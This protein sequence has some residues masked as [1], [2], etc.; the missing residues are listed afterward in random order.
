MV[1]RELLLLIFIHKK[2]TDIKKPDFSKYY[3]V[4]KDKKQKGKK[5]KKQKIERKPGRRSHERIYSN[6][7]RKLSLDEDGK[8][9]KNTSRLE[10]STEKKKP[11][12]ERLDN[13]GRLEID[14]KSPKKDRPQRVPGKRRHSSI[15]SS[16]KKR[17][18]SYDSEGRPLTNTGRLNVDLSKKKEKKEWLD[19]FSKLEVGLDGSV[20]RSGSFDKEP[21]AL[22]KPGKGYDTATKTKKTDRKYDLKT[23]PQTALIDSKYGKTQIKTTTTSQKRQPLSTSTY[24]TGKKPISQKLQ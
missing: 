3:S 7:K 16:K 10:V 20:K 23:K 11:K 12:R 24:G 5:E 1:K 6:T 18:E 14:A 17:K 22:Y 15:H 19:N 21:R 2:T 8:P 13:T 4:E 9:L